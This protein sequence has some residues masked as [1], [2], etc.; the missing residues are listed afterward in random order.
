[1]SAYRSSPIFLAQKKK[2]LLPYRR[3]AKYVP[4][5]IHR[6]V[7]LT[8]NSGCFELISR[9]CPKLTKL[10]ITANRTLND[11]D[12]S[13]FADRLPD[14]QLSFIIFSTLNSYSSCP[15]FISSNYFLTVYHFIFL[16]TSDTDVLFSTVYLLAFTLK[17][18]LAE[19]LFSQFLKK[20]FKTKI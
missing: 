6:C 5:W 9:S 18:C 17:F 1:M 4:T 19:S 7:G 13:N 10:F 12:V 3:L 20:N 16:I 14:L 15:S 8:S 2:S 11:R